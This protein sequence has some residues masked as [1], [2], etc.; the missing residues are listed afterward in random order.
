L[1]Y[2]QTATRTLHPTV[3]ATATATRTLH[4]TVTATATATRTLHPTV[5]ATATATRTPTDLPIPTLARAAS[6]SPILLVYDAQS[7]VAFNRSGAAVDLSDL[8]FVQIAMDGR[9]LRFNAR[10]WANGGLNRAGVLE[11]GACFQVWTIAIT[12]L[13]VP[14]YCGA[15]QAWRMVGILHT[16]WLPIDPA[17]AA[18]S[19]LVV[20]AFEVRRGEVVVARCAL[21]AGECALTP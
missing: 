21:D 5:T 8:V 1:A 14:S 6:D 15:R 16:F 13:P 20:A 10:Q 12:D 18:G 4:P 19:A 3:T 2:T 7:L 9:D 17:R 11:A